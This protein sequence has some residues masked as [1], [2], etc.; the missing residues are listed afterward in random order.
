MESPPPRNL[1]PGRTGGATGKIAIC[2]VGPTVV[3]R[4]ATPGQPRPLLHPPADLIEN[5]STAGNWAD[6]L[7][8]PASSEH[9]ASANDF[10]LD[11]RSRVRPHSMDTGAAKTAISASSP[12]AYENARATGHRQ[13]LA[14]SKQWGPVSLP[15]TPTNRSQA[16]LDRTACHHANIVHHQRK[17][18][19]C[20]L[21]VHAGG[22]MLAGCRGL[23]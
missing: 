8:R 21:T 20:S 16:L 15:E 13:P 5:P 19:S 3:A 10:D 2:L 1:L 7:R 14:P 12:Q 18:K 17:R 11:R 22:R 6:K 23:V 4:R 9:P